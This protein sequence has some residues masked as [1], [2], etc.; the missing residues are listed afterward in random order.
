MLI[1][2]K[3]VSRIDARSK[4]IGEALY[5]GDIDMPDQVYMKILFADRPHAI[6]KEIDTSKAESLPGVIA[7]FTAKDVPQNEYGLIMPDQPVLC[8]RVRANPMRIGFY[9]SATK[10]PW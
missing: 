6:I 10:S 9:G 1:L 3:P 7:V 4:V 2:G 5:P 8:V